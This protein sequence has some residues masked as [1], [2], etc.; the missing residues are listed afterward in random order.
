LIELVVAS[1]EST[2]NGVVRVKGH[3]KMLQTRQELRNDGARDGIVHALVN[4]G[5]HISVFLA[6]LMAQRNLP[7]RIIG[8]TKL[9]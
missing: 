7:C 8:E 2:S 3:V 9:R 5:K 6:Q 1:K 4:R